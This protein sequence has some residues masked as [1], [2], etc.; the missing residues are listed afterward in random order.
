VL[1]RAQDKEQLGVFDRRIDRL[2]TSSSTTAAAVGRRS[3][4][5]RG[6]GGHHNPRRTWTAALDDRP[7]RR[8]PHVSPNQRPAPALFSGVRVTA[9]GGVFPGG[10]IDTRVTP[11]AAGFS[12]SGFFLS[13]G[14]SLRIG[15][16]GQGPA[17]RR[18]A[19]SA[20]AAGALEPPVSRC[21][22]PERGAAPPPIDSLTQFELQH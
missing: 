12:D 8:P 9:P 18:G 1:L 21:T 17:A 10:C 6:D 14:V 4:C 2:L 3:G 16:R 15:V 20:L 22:F 7:R 5:C 13:L 19:A 11:C